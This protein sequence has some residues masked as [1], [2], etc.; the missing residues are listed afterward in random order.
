LQFKGDTQKLE[1]G[2]VQFFFRTKVGDEELS[3]ALISLYTAPDVT[4]LAHS[5]GTLWSCEYQAEAELRVIP[6]K[7]I[8][9]VVGM[10]PHR[11]DRFFVTEKLG[12]EV[13]YM[14]GVEEEMTE[15]E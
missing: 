12:L 11:D 7:S 4:L 15:D 10:V 9:S 3:F 1:F 2:E 8:I 5:H 6:A 14:G 13:A